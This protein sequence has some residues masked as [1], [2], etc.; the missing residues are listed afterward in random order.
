MNN[1]V[2]IYQNF[3]RV[4]KMV[5]IDGKE[6]INMATHDYHSMVDNPRVEKSSLDCLAI[7]G[8]GSCGPR[9]F[10]GT[11]QVHV[12]LEERVSKFMNVGETVLY[13]YGFASIAS[14]I[15]AYSKR[16]DVIFC[17]EGANFAIQRAIE[18]SRSHVF[19][20]KHN[21]MDDFRRYLEMQRAKDLKN[22]KKAKATR[23]FLL[24]E[25]IYMN[26]G[27]ICPLPEILELTKEFK[28]R[29]FID[30]TTSLGVLGKTGRGV[31][32]HF[33][34]PIDE[35]DIVAATLES[36]VG[37]YGGFSCGSSFVV[38]HQRLSS[39]GYC[40]SASLPPMQARAA[41]TGLDI[42]DEDPSLLDKL[43]TNS[44][45]IQDKLK[46]IKGI[47]VVGDPIS[48]VKH[49]RLADKNISN[50]QAVTIL[51]NIVDEALKSGVALTLARY[52]EKVECF[53][54]KPSIRIAVRSHLEDFD[55]SKVTKVISQSCKNVLSGL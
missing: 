44:I 32:E 12:E 22:M 28:V 14:I 4:G 15:P 11:S 35:I 42:I 43:R 7:Y 25:G 18:A 17:D 19:Y 2:Y 37:A 48:P 3:R 40:F 16:G 39:L 51:E 55:L 31:T 21:D 45:K 6:C 20:F 36:A 41:I 50:D 49:I 30:E 9:T 26:S 54:V 29:I 46:Q 10:L 52:L 27:D 23:R 38:D 24:L 33:N 8:V 47:E 13:S 5:S 34:I 53:P 1:E